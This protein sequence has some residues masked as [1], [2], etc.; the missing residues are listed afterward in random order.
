MCNFGVVESRGSIIV[1]FECINSFGQE[2]VRWNYGNPLP[3]DLGILYHISYGSNPM[4]FY[5]C[6]MCQTI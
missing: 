1:E 4:S 3:C 5:V 6:N 2:F